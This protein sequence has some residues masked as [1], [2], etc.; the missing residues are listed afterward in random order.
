M[1]P[2]GQLEKE[3]SGELSPH[4]I[5]YLVLIE[6]V[7]LLFANLKRYELTFSQ[8]L[9]VGTPLKGVKVTLGSG[10]PKEASGTLL[11][12]TVWV[13]ESAQFKLFVTLSLTRYCCVPV[14]PIAFK[15]G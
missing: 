14:V 1:T 10:L 15:N 8:R 11:T 12:V 2:A 6:V 4:L 9:K 5:V 7:V 3:L 13:V